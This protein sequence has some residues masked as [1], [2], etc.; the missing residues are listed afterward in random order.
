MEVEFKIPRQLL[1]IEANVIAVANAAFRR[2]TADARARARENVTRGRPGLI[3][4][5][6]ALYRGI[7]LGPYVQ[8]APGA[9]AEQRIYVKGPAARYAHVHEYGAV[10]R[11]KRKPWLVFRLYQPWDTDR[12]T[13]PW[14]RAKQVRIPKRPFL[15]PAARAAADDFPRH[16]AEAATR[17]LGR[18]HT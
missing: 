12:P 2:T 7:S 18:F 15:W 14:R 5:S 10:I 13:G 4:R 1:A 16:F 11:A 9:I 3:A 6:G 8:R 17:I